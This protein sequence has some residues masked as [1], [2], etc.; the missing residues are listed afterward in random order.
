M[1][2]T[3]SNDMNDTDE[4]IDTEPDPESGGVVP[5]ALIDAVMASVDAGGIEL[6]GEN[7]AIAELTKR[8]LERGLNEELAD[9]LGYEPGDQSG[10]G[11]G[12][13]RNG[14][15]A[16]KVL[17][18]IGAV[19]LEIPRD[20]NGTFEPQLVPKHSRRMEQFNTNIVHLYARGLST[21]DIR[22]ELKRMYHVDVSPALVSKVTDGIID[23]LNDWQTRPLDAVYPIMYID[24]L[25]V[26]VRTG[27]TVINRAAYLG[28]GVDVEGRKHVLGVWLGDG[29]EGAKF[30]LN[31]LTEIRTRGATDVLLVCCD[32]LKGLPDAI[33]ATWPQALVQ[34]C[35][36]HLIR[37]STR[38]CSYKDRRAVAA[39]LKPIYTAATVESAESAMDD[40]EIEWGDRYPGIVRTWRSAWEQFT[41]FL[42]FP[43]EIRKIV[44]TTNMVESINFQLRKVTKTRG[45]FPTDQSALKLL[46]LA[47][48][49]VSDKR[50]GDLGTG[51]RGWSH[52]LN[53]FDIHFPGRLGL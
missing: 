26:K 43:P 32:G 46:R 29:D 17:T 49:N 7:G 36:I 20:R 11:S 24:A 52:A 37:A 21:R 13:N 16:K 12:N 44:Y 30:W 40:F 50:G 42:R 19:D 53:A 1:T 9:H 10:R 6:L 45:H 47:A 27:G 39:A 5:D 31:V 14:T 51:T 34:T 38:F 3:D 4:I 35:V 48:R 28:I 22:R 33:E 2:L 8:I 23:E 41:P 18:E 15:S 25:V